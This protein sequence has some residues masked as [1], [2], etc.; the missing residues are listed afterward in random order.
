MAD[1]GSRVKEL[2]KSKGLTQRKMA[3]ILGITERN[4]QRYEAT[5]SPSNENLLKMAN[6]FKVPTDYLLGRTDDPDFIVVNEQIKEVMADKELSLKAK[7]LYMQL[8]YYS[9]DN[10]V[11]INNVEEFLNINR[12]SKDEF[13]GAISELV[14]QKYIANQNKLVYSFRNS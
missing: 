7:G 13:D 6:F 12:I 5:N 3:D 8:C 9:Y 11:E 14:E 2:R 1:F 10:K 4:Y